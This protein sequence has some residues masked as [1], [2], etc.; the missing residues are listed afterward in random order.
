MDRDE[1]ALNSNPKR[2]EELEVSCKVDAEYIYTKC[3]EML[4]EKHHKGYS[5]ENPIILSALM[6][7]ATQIF[8][9]KPRK[10]KYKEFSG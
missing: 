5:E 6:N 4:D 7:S 2:L 8:I 9:N 3:V 1:R 10:N